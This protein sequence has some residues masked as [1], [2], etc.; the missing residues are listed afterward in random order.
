MS[1]ESQSEREQLSDDNELEMDADSADSNAATDYSAKKA[2]LEAKCQE[3]Q[4]AIAD[5]HELYTQILA[6]LSES[7]LRNLNALQAELAQLGGSIPGLEKK[8]IKRLKLAGTLTAIDKECSKM[9]NKAS[10][11]RKK[12]LQR[13]DDFIS[14]SMKALRAL[15]G[16]VSG[17]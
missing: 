9:K 4:S 11:K 14:D 17:T 12:D 8:S 2:V 1:R 15:N 5:C 16:K 3:L 13:M 7:H 10:Q 6:S